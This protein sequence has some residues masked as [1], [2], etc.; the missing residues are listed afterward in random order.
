MGCGYSG[1]FS[2]ME[3]KEEIKMTDK[4]NPE[5]AAKGIGR[6]RETLLFALHSIL[7]ALCAAALLSCGITFVK[8][9]CDPARMNIFG[10]RLSFVLSRS[11]EP[12][13]RT[14]A[15]CLTDM[16]HREPSVGDIV[17]CRHQYEDG[18]AILIVH[19]VTAVQK[20]GSILTKGDNNPEPDGWVTPKE[21]II[22]KVV[23]V[24]NGFPEMHR[25]ISGS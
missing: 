23:F 5:T 24:W 25:I 21:D 20:D 19:R 1:L 10:Y 15:L 14:H 3:G 11:M 13:I 8:S 6:I 12:A 7:P 4:E 17:V 22:G 2:R 16:I 9:G 18:P